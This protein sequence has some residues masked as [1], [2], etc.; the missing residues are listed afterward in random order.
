MLSHQP[1]TDQLT[2]P[3]ARFMSPTMPP[4]SLAQLAVKAVWVKGGEVT[5]HTKCRLSLM[6]AYLQGVQERGMFAPS[7][8][9][10]KTLMSS[11]AHLL[12]KKNDAMSVLPMLEVSL[13]ERAM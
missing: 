5:G 3:G 1:P 10:R 9:G 12:V 13:E 4:C 11:R 6:I 8:L 2:A 7:A